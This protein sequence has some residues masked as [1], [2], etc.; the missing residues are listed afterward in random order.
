M[1]G[2]HG[3]GW[4]KGHGERDVDVHFY[5]ERPAAR[6]KALLTQE[7]R[8]ATAKQAL[9]SNGRRDAFTL[10]DLY[11]GGYTRGCSSTR[12]MPGQTRGTKTSTTTHRSERY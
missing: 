5:G 10:C 11:M 9:R 3:E 8:F 6:G 12:E 7:A 4:T 1:G 2:S